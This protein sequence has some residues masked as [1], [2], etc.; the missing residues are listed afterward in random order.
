VCLLPAF[1]AAGNGATIDDYLEAIEYTIGVVGEEQVAVG[2]DFIDGHGREF[3]EWLM[4]DK[5]TSRVVTSDR[6]EELVEPQMLAGIERISEFPNLTASMLERGWSEQRVRRVMGENWL[7][8]F[9]D[10]WVDPG[11]AA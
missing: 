5:G 2:T 10:V 4:R 9:S 7:R 3:L 6:I 1:L 8:L 11:A